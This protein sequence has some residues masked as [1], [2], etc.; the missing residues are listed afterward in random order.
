MIKV[1]DKVVCINNSYIHAGK[2]KFFSNIKPGN[3]Y[4]I[5]P[6][7]TKYFK[8]IAI[9]GYAFNLEEHDGSQ[10]WYKDHFITLAEWREQQIKVV[11]N[12]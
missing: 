10:W 3:V 1:G 7:N 9:A 5:Q 4:E 12:E 11:L 8:Y 2:L 6:V